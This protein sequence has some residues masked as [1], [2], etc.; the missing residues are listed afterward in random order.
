[1]RWW[2]RPLCDHM[3]IDFELSSERESPFQ[4]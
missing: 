4:A 3:I 1:M 2:S